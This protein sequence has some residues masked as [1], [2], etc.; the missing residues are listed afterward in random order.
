M[1]HPHLHCTH[2]E[3]FTFHYSTSTMKQSTRLL[4]GLS[5]SFPKKE[6][7]VYVPL[8][9]SA[10]SA[11]QLP[12][13]TFDTQNLYA[14]KKTKFGHWPVY[15]KIQNTKISTEIKRV[16]GNVQ[17]FASELTKFVQNG[18]ILPRNLKV[19]TLTGEVNIKGDHVSEIKS[20]LDR[21]IKL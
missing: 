14:I 21:H 7:P 2:Q 9:L 10:I 3:I 16:E 15:K 6:V 5:I 19:N 1:A 18:N 13:N 20:I 11:N 12:N 17:L 4:K 8:S